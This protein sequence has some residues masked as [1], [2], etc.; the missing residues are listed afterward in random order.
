MDIYAKSGTLVKFTHPTAGY[1]HHQKLASEF[2]TVNE[3]YTVEATD[4]DSY[5]TDVYL[6]EFPGKAFNSVLFSDV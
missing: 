6:K 1:S 5:H 3:V 4:V 2:L